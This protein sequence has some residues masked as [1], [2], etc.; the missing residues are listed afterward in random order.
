M[1]KTF[2][3]LCKD[4]AKITEDRVEAESPAIKDTPRRRFE[5]CKAEL[6]VLVA[7]NGL[8]VAEF[9]VREAAEFFAYG[10]RTR[11]SLDEKAPPEPAKADDIIKKFAKTDAN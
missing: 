8:Q 7:E 9:D 4:A 3:E 6:S 11:L 1:A 2:S 10:Y 5:V